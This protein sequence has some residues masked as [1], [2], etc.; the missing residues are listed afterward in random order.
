MFNVPHHNQNARH[1]TMKAL[2]GARVRSPLGEQK[3]INKSNVLERI[4]FFNWSNE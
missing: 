1:L 3:N 2:E 4:R